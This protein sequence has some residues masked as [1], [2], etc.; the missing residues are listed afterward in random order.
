VKQRILITGIGLTAPNGNNLTEFRDALVRGVSGISEEDIRYMGKQAAGFCDFD[1]KKY[2]SRK[3]RRRGTRAG[4]ISVYCANEALADAGLNI[5]EIPKDR[6]GVFVGITEHGNV[7]TENEVYEMHQ[8]NLDYKLWTPHHNPRTVAN[9]PA[10]EVT[11][12]LKI[13]GPHYTIGSACAG[14]NAGLIQGVQ[15]ILLGEV[16]YA[17]AGGISESPQTFGIFAGFAAQGALGYNEEDIT[18]SIKPMDKNRQGTVIAEGGCLYIL[19]TLENAKARGAK[20]IAEIVGYALNSDATD[21]VNPHTQ[22]QIECMQ[23]AMDRAG[24]KPSDIDIVNMH[25]T[26][27]GAG[28]ISEAAA[29]NGAF[30]TSDSTYVNFTKGHIGHSMG[31]AGALELAGNIPAFEDGIVHLGLNVDDPDPECEVK[32]IVIRESKYVGNINY[33]LNNSFGMLGINST[34]IVKK[35]KDEE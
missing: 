14:G 9:N 6:V 3:A 34:V 35:Y 7:V 22:R 5:E 18:K 12:N 29:V 30:E 24:V 23:K 13:T 17:I 31:A 33:I 28:D 10:G 26:G 27:T 16:D 20:V 25:A 1:E 21:Y 4:S 32:N 19:E 2:H 15:Q 11:L 8:N